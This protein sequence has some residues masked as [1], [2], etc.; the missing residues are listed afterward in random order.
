MKR[1]KG[2]DKA[3]R[4]SWAHRRRS[5]DQ[6]TNLED[7]DLVSLDGVEVVVH[8]K[9]DLGG[10]ERGEGLEHREA[11]IPTSFYI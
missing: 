1:D 2:D 11:P 7:E 6:K 9:E 10:N 3:E 5:I 8:G 4:K